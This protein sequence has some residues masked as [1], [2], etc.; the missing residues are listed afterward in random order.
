[1]V[2]FKK[3]WEINAYSTASYFKKGQMFLIAS[4]YFFI[5]KNEL[6]RLKFGFCKAKIIISIVHKRYLY[7]YF[8]LV[9]FI[10]ILFNFCKN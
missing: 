3:Y 7:S 10:G 8:V 2:E 5:F 4:A 6:I 9:I 1:M